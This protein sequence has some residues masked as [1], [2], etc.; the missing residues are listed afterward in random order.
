MPRKS[1]KIQCPEMVCGIP[2]A[3]LEQFARFICPYIEEYFADEKNMAEYQKLKASG[4]FSQDFASKS[5]HFHRIIIAHSPHSRH[6]GDAGTQKAGANRFL[7]GRVCP[8]FLPYH[9]GNIPHK[10]NYP[11]PEN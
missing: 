7:H 3:N 4:K 2:R 6:T 10:S 1:K 8:G 9:R 11:N 5:S